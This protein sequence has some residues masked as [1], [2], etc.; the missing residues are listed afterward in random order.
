MV[1]ENFGICLCETSYIS[2]ILPSTPSLFCKKILEFVLVKLPVFGLKYAINSFTMVKEEFGICFCETSHTALILPF[3]PSPWLRKILEFIFARR[4]KLLYL[5]DSF[6]IV[7]EHFGNCPCETPQID[8]KV[9]FT[10]SPWLKKTLE[11]VF[12]KRLIL[13]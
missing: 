10:L 5:I 1:E 8:I 6:H 11:F 7:K 9:S 3:T 12:V 13:P 2:L 4:L